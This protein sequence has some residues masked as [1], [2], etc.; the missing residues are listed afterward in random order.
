MLRYR[1]SYYLKF[2]MKTWVVILSAMIVAMAKKNATTRGSNVN[3]GR[4]SRKEIPEIKQGDSFYFLK[5][6]AR[7]MISSSSTQV[8]SPR[9][10]EVFTA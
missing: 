3:N 4:M 5:K 8:P 2:A 7:R 6:D 10:V 9:N 1:I